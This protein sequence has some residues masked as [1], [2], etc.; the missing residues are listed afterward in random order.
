MIIMMMTKMITTT[1]SIIAMLTM[2]H[3][4]PIQMS[5]ELNQN[6]I[7]NATPISLKTTTIIQIPTTTATTHHHRNH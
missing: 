6:P 1:I 7:R 3:S 5:L 4:I 2:K